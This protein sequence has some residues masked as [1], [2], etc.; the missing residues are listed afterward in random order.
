VV[1]QERA[2]GAGDVAVVTGGA[3]GIGAAVVERL[4]NAGTEVVVWDITP[5]DDIVHCDVA[6]VRSVAAAMDATIARAG[7][8]TS[9]I[10]CAGVAG[11]GFV[12]SFDLAGLDRCLAVNLRGVAATVQA[13]AR[14]M[15]AE[16]IRGSI[17]AVSSVSSFMADVGTAPY[18][19]S[20]AGVNILVRI[21]ARELGPFGIRVNAVAPGATVTPM[22]EDL[23]L[24]PDI[25]ET[26]TRR[27]PLRR[28]GAPDDI[29]QAIVALS[30]SEWVTGHLFVVDGGSSL[31]TGRQ[32]LLSGP[33][34][35]L[36][37]EFPAIPSAFYG[38]AVPPGIPNSALEQR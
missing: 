36:R 16:R 24:R 9:V 35:E 13:A 34:H 33:D 32:E 8:P 29:A 3:S 38:T 27:I 4:R 25:H 10:A 30:A 2:S 26:L 5:G 20:K 12:E 37:S 1:Q 31:M 18:A 7:C 14:A 19:M 23:L 6:D 28:L 17:V 15:L 22:V 21:A 11:G